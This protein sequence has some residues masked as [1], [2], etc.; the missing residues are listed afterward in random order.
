M[1]CKRRAKM[2]RYFAHLSHAILREFCIYRIG[3]TYLWYP[4]AGGMWALLTICYIISVICYILF[5][6][7]GQDN[8]QARSSMMIMFKI[9][10]MG[11]SSMMILVK[12]FHRIY[13][14]WWFWSVYFIGCIKY[15]G[16][17][18][19]FTVYNIYNDSGQD[20]SQDISTVM[21]WSRYFTGYVI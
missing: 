18:R 1:L 2:L 15:D 19:Y 16:W 20:I 9:I 3:L 6:G 11:V 12:I 13:P 10:H 14:L 8:S 5:D 7:S 17:L 4:M 21:F